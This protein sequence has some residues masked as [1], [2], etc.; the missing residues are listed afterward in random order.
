MEIYVSY[1]TLACVCRLSDFV[2]ICMSNGNDFQFATTTFC[3]SWLAAV[4]FLFSELFF[5]FEMIS[6]FVYAIF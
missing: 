1:F 3:S 4:I 2:D 5:V 6:K